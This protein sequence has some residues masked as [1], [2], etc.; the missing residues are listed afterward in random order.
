MVSLTLTPA[1]RNAIVHCEQR[2]LLEAWLVDLHGLQ[3]G[4]AISHAQLIGLSRSA[5]DDADGHG[6]SLDS[7]MKG[8]RIVQSSSRPK[9][10][11][12]SFVTPAGDGPMRRIANVV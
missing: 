2:G 3:V 6:Y 8:S 1:A 11:P 10:E 12:V 4:D 7:L 9:P 5:R